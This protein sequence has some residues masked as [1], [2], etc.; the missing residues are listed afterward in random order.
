MVSFEYKLI[1]SVITCEGLDME[2]SGRDVSIDPSMFLS[3]P[4]SLHC[5]SD[6]PFITRLVHRSILSTAVSREMLFIILLLVLSTVIV[7][8]GS[9]S[10]L[11]DDVIAIVGC[12]CLGSIAVSMAIVSVAFTA[13]L[14]EDEG[15]KDVVVAAG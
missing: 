1:I 9:E 8:I 13:M 12:S 3:Y 10:S 7:S 6:S 15:I 4:T 14:N 11:D 2:N 5:I